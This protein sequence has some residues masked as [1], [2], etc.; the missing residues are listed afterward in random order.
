MIIGRVSGGGTWAW[1][2]EGVWGGLDGM[3]LTGRHF[4]VGAE[5]G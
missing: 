4:V 2:D 5:G 3:G 1:L